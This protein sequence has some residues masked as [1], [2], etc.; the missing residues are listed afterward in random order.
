MKAQPNAPCPCGSRQKYKKCCRRYHLGAL[1]PDALT[2]MKSRYSAYAF[3]QADY[4]I[5]T[6]H[7]S[8]PEYTDDTA[9]WKK[10][11]VAFGRHTE[12]IR[13]EI[14]EHTPKEKE[15]FVHFKAH[16]SSGILE[17]KSRFVFEKG[18]WLYAGK[19]G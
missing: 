15:A 2:L 5:A 14:V 12:F 4:I 6:T 11:I 7:P 8:S 16:L 17:E 3:E 10:E 19:E 1:A 9:Q 13:L 18:R